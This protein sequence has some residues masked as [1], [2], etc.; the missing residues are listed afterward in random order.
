MPIS[1]ISLTSHNVC[2]FLL[3][4]SGQGLNIEQ[5]TRKKKRQPLKRSL[6]DRTLETTGKASRQIEAAVVHEV[7]SP[8]S[9]L[10]SQNMPKEKSGSQATRK[11]DK[12]NVSLLSKVLN[13]ERREV[14]FQFRD[15]KEMRDRVRA[16]RQ[17]DESK[18]IRICFSIGLCAME[19]L[20]KRGI[21]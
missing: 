21:L 18:L 6:R 17:E 15:T 16:L 12:G 19:D 9:R 10:E 20:K 5:V 2:L 14:F 7:I 11:L 8:R 4:R 3:R 13:P 1:T